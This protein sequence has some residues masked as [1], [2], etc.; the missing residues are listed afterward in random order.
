[1]NNFPFRLLAFMVGFCILIGAGPV[2]TAPE[3]IP[4]DKVVHPLLKP[5][6]PPQIIPESRK[7]PVYPEKWQE[8]H[9]GARVILQCV[10]EK[11]GSV[12]ECQ[13]LK[14][15]VWVETDC[16]ED[17]GEGAG[18][19]EP[20]REAGTPEAA[21]D[22]EAAALDAVKEWKYRPGVS[23]GKPVDIFFTLIVDF[24]LCPKKAD[25]QPLPPP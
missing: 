9:L 10:V 24:T 5:V 14:T 1:M 3:K 15:D 25:A 21:R 6:M 22:F 12:G 19:E 17:P 8:L 16:G 13:A 23:E 11:S 7:D 20:R 4:P 18:G 2:P